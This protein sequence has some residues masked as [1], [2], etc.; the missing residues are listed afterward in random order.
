VRLSNDKAQTASSDWKVPL[1]ERLFF[2][3]DCEVHI[4]LLWLSNYLKGSQ[5]RIDVPKV[6]FGCG[7]LSYSIRAEGRLFGRPHNKALRKIP[8]NTPTKAT[9]STQVVRETTVQTKE[10]F[11]NVSAT[12]AE[13]GKLL[14]DSYST[15]VKSAEEYNAKVMEFARTNTQ[16]NLEFV[17]KLS[18]AKSPTELLELWTNHSRRQFEALAQQARELLSLAQKTMLTTT[19][20]V[21]TDVNKTYSQRP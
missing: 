6:S 17:Q 11:E 16:T 12:T 8:L 15:A 18:N 5:D 14:R 13:A 20:R 3:H 21:Q 1:L 7:D 10:A 9:N 19:E 2:D 4:V